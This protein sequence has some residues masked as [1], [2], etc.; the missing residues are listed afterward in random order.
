M[1]RNIKKTLMI[2]LMAFFV[3]GVGINVQ[4]KADTLGQVKSVKT[5]GNY[6][7]YKGI[8]SAKD[9]RYRKIKYKYF[10]RETSTVFS[11]Y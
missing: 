1:I 11:L 9:M 8:V 4:A 7:Y 10:T 3:L 2:V 5:K 6:R